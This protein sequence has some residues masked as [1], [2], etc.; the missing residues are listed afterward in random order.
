MKRIAAFLC[1]AAFAVLVLGR[2]TSF[3]AEPTAKFAE[4]G[5]FFETQKQL[6]ALSRQEQHA[7][8][9]SVMQKLPGSEQAAYAAQQSAALAA[10]SEHELLCEGWLAAKGFSETYVTLYDGGAQVVLGA[11][12]ASENNIALV[13][14]VLWRVA[15]VK[16]GDVYITFR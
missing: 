2:P 15:G 14:E 5:S 6:R 9:D 4:N 3:L 12:A 10:R 13:C 11:D 1:L 8:Y 7:Y 16:A